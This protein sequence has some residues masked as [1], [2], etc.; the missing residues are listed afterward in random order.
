M[1]CI[2]GPQP[3]H[4]P[5]TREVLFAWWTHREEVGLRGVAIEG[6]GILT[7]SLAGENE[8]LMAFGEQVHYSIPGPLYLGKTNLGRKRA[9]FK[10]TCAFFP[11]VK[12]H[13]EDGTEAQSPGVKGH[14][15]HSS[16]SEDNG[17]LELGAPRPR[18]SACATRAPCAIPSGHSAVPPFRRQSFSKPHGRH[19]TKPTIKSASARG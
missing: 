6:R 14:R 13:R 8:D 11:L 3:T 2:L 10:T 18:S 9:T 5:R 19:F 12:P 17:G 1:G 16:T 4:Q 15:Q 7:K